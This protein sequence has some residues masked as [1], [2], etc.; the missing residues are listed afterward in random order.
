MT[1]AS[2][3]K[4]ACFTRAR[5]ATVWVVVITIMEGNLPWP[6]TV[7]LSAPIV[8]HLV[9]EHSGLSRCCPSRH[10]GSDA[11]RGHDPHPIADPPRATLSLTTSFDSSELEPNAEENHDN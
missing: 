6:R 1:S 4:A 3:S 9:V 8:P 10:L 5:C 7:S 11:Q 2:A